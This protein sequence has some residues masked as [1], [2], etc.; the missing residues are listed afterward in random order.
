MTRFYLAHADADARGDAAFTMPL[1]NPVAYYF[2]SVTMLGA[3]TL[4][5]LPARRWR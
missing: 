2:R 1:S 3:M 4:G 5:P